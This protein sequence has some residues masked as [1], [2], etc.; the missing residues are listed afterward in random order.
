[1]FVFFWF[2]DEG[3]SIKTKTC[4]KRFGKRSV[5]EKRRKGTK[6]GHSNNLQNGVG[7]LGQNST[8]SFLLHVATF[9][10]I[11]E[12]C[13]CDVCD[14]CDECVMCVCVC[15]VCDIYIHIIYIYICVCVYV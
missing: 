10:E 4:S 7:S 14:V 5:E 13:V 3:F 8:L 6:V 9:L 1:M 2:V 12:T 11:D 15:V